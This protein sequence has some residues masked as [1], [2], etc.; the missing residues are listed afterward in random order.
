MSWFIKEMRKSRDLEADSPERVVENDAPR[1][2]VELNKSIGVPER[3][4]GPLKNGCG[5]GE[6]LGNINLARIR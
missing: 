3:V 6:S 5:L 4:L 1:L 2:A